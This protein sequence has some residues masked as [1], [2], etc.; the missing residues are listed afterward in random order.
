MRRLVGWLR[1]ESV[2]WIIPAVFRLQTRADG[3]SQ[4]DR[5]DLEIPV[6]K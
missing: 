5:D 3:I 6:G 1:G 2:K 4:R